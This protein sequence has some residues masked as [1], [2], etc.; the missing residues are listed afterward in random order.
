MF[1]V[2]ARN[3]RKRSELWRGRGGRGAAKIIRSK[4]GKTTRSRNIFIRVARI[5]EEAAFSVA[6]R[7]KPLESLIGF[8]RLAIWPVP[9]G[10]FSQTWPS[11][12]A[13][14][15]SEIDRL[16]FTVQFIHCLL[17]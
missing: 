6:A 12:V 4:R 15:T 2:F 1:T 16:R 13:H 3:Y 17:K 7:R 5:R 9:L 14:I 10:V 8:A 11:P